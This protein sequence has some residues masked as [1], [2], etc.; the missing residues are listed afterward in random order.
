MTLA[1][2]VW[3]P[4]ISLSLHE[5]ERKNDQGAG[6]RGQFLGPAPTPRLIKHDG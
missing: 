4:S 5:I 3:T 1:V 6:S 2:A